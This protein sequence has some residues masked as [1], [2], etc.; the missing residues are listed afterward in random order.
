MALFQGSA[1]SRAIMEPLKAAMAKGTGQRGRDP[2]TTEDRIR[3]DFS[4]GNAAAERA[5]KTNALPTCCL[6]T[7]PAGRRIAACVGRLF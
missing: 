3:L 5:A 2:V 7:L 1:V 6:T 4:P